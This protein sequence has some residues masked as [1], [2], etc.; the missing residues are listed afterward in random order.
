MMEDEEGF[1]SDGEG[2]D[3]ELDDMCCEIQD[4]WFIRD[5][6]NAIKEAKKAVE[7]LKT[8]D[9]TNINDTFLVY[10]LLSLSLREIGD[11]NGALNYLNDLVKNSEFDARLSPGKQQRV[12]RLAAELS[13]LTTS[14]SSL[15]VSENKLYALFNLF[16]E[17]EDEGAGAFYDN[18]SALLWDVVLSIVFHIDLL[19][20]TNATADSINNFNS[21][22]NNP[23]AIALSTDLLAVL[24]AWHSIQVTSFFLMVTF[25]NATLSISSAMLKK[26]RRNSKRSQSETLRRHQGR[27]RD[28]PTWQRSC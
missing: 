2:R 12:L 16:Q 9:A 22:V 6:E 15:L 19:E 26:V 10:E 5:F 21:V 11:Y 20:N 14:I 7:H 27:S 17:V 4:Y 3:E 18:K 13:Y 1:E 25:L 24:T 8:S 23:Q 28:C